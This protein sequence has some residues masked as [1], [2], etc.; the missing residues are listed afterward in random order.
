MVGSTR[1]Q[2]S[3]HIDIHLE[4]EKA[5]ERQGQH[6]RTELHLSPPVSNSSGIAS[7][8]ARFNIPLSD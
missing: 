7:V 8:G 2:R 5:R 6:E 1:Y 3:P 4:I